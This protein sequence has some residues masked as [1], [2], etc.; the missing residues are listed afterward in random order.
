[1]NTNPTNSNPTNQPTITPTPTQSASSFAPTN[2][3]KE[4]DKTGLIK[5]IIIAV[6]MI[7]IIILGSYIYIDQMAKKK[8]RD[9]A[10]ADKQIPGLIYQI[11]DDARNFYEKNQSYKEWWPKSETLIQISNLGTTAIYRKPDFQSFV[12][13]AYSQTDRKYFCVDSKGFADFIDKANDEQVK[14]Q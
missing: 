3:T 12:I 7:A 11:R 5:K 14:C 4:P 1:M 10:T 13:Y 8:V 2:S 6:I 9:Q